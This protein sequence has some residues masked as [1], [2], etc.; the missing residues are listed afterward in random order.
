MKKRK[1]HA[2]RQGARHLK[3]CCWELAPWNFV[4]SSSEPF[5]GIIFQNKVYKRY[6]GPSYDIHTYPGSLKHNENRKF[7]ARK[8]SQTPESENF[9]SWGARRFRQFW[10]LARQTIVCEKGGARQPADFLRQRFFTVY[11][12]KRVTLSEREGF[13]LLKN[14]FPSFQ[15]INA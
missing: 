14:S 4:F 11:I 7:Q 6:V 13:N 5:F 10:R 9:C 8:R 1:F 15:L 2:A 3:K 12:I